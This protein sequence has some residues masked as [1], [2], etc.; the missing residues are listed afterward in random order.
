LLEVFGLREKADDYAGTLSG[1]QRK[2]LELAR[3]YIALTDPDGARAVLRQA[4]DILL[5]RPD[6]GLLPAEADELRAKV[7]T[8]RRQG[9]GGGSS[10]TTAELRVLPL[11]ATHL[12]FRE[13]GERLDVP[14]LVLHD[15]GVHRTRQRVAGLVAERLEG[16]QRQAL[17]EPERV[18]ILVEVRLQ[19]VRRRLP[20]RVREG[21]RS[22][23][24]RARALG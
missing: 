21:G 10:L 1:G 20:R 2:L 9:V 19:P 15:V 24:R 16:G 8:I 4:H 23:R 22:R 18:R 14:G 3:A 13:I 17:G 11:M 6:L 7:E 5:Q 12:S